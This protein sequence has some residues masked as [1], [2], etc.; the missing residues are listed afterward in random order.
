MAP[1]LLVRNGF[2]E[3][4]TS[5]LCPMNFHRLLSS[6]KKMALTTQTQITKMIFN[7]SEAPSSLV[8]AKEKLFQSIRDH[9]NSHLQQY[10]S[11]NAQ[12]TIQTC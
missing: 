11:T 4:F 7:T 8:L 2:Q 1:K 3:K 12:N 9:L 5:T 10:H 6:F